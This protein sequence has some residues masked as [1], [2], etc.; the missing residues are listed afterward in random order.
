[1]TPSDAQQA[2][3]H[4][5]EQQRQRIL[6]LPAGRELDALVAEMLGWYLEA[7]TGIW[8]APNAH[9]RGRAP[10]SADKIPPYSTDPGAA[11][12]MLDRFWAVSIDRCEGVS[13]RYAVT[14]NA[15]DGRTW[16]ARDD[17][18]A[19]AAARCALLATLEA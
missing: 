17:S 11:W 10:S 19:L 3:A 7:D 1:M 14:I 8:W 4:D 12:A 18:F 13:P 16:D 15:R 5:A 2:L 6:S 9:G